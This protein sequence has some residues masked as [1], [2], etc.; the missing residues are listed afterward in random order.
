[1]A[2]AMGSRLK[3]KFLWSVACVERALSRCCS[4]VE[5]WPFE[6]AT[7]VLRGLIQHGY[8]PLTNWD[9]PPSRIPVTNEGL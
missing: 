2:A 5:H 1:M 6:R 9:D 7:T 4:S 3:D 8:E